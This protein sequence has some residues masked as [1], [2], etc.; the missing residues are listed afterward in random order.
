MEGFMD[1]EG[2]VKKVMEVSG[3]ESLNPPQRLALDAGLLEGKNLVVATPTASGKTAIAEI[4]CLKTIREG[5]KT[6]YI[7]PLK[8]LATEKYNEFK[9]KYEP[10]GVKVAVSIGDFDSSG[11]WL[12][13][14][15]LIVTTSERLDSLLRH[16]IGWV[17][18]VGLIVADE[19]HLLDSPERG[20]TL[21]IVLTRIAQ[22]ARPR[23]LALSATIN[24]YKELASWLGAEGI[25][26][27]Y[28][29][30]KLH[31]GL[32]F[33]DVVDFVPKKK[34]RLERGKDPTLAIVEENLKN[35]KQVLVFV[36]TRR[37]AEAGAEKLGENVK[38]LLSPAEKGNL[39]KVAEKVERSLEHTTRQCRRLAAC[40]RNGVAFHHAGETAQQRKLIEDAFRKGIIKV[41]AATPTLSWGINLPAY[42]V[43]VRD[44]K[45]FS[46]YRGMDYLP[47][48]EVH[49]MM[50]RAGRPKYDKEGRAVLIAKNKREAEYAWENYINGEPENIKSKLGV[51]PVLRMHILALIASGV[52]SKKK[53]LM[54]FF[55][56]TFYA[57]QF[58]DIGLLEGKVEKVLEM[59]EGFGF[60]EIEGKKPGIEKDSAFRR[61]SDV[62]SEE[63][64]LRPTKIGKRVSELYI[65]PLT[66]DHMIKNLKRF[67]DGLSPFGLLQTISDTIEMRP[68]PGLR[69]KD[70]EY[71]DKAVAQEGKNLVVPNEWDLEYD[72][73]LRS[74]KLA[75]TLQQW[76][77]EAGEDRILEDYNMTPGE[78]RARLNNA[79]WLLY[80]ISELALLLGQMGVLKGIRK[81]RVRMKYGVREE[82]LALVKLEG[83][84]RVRARTLFKSGLKSLAALRKVPLESL[85][86]IVGPK[87]ARD[88][89]E[90]LGEL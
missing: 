34:M 21:E 24:N 30:V 42:T 76:V 87:T 3:F 72:D 52:T 57:H 51:E 31:R 32:C 17:G 82:L 14:F 46:S 64:E 10:L 55:A 45:R 65:D 80:A 62:V 5:K 33:K 2:I 90:Q 15:D 54:D 89:K 50:G 84:G 61:A 73:F 39:A 7:V 4:S 83:I 13:R 81:M 35:K 86:R 49:Q 36:S 71:L 1:V 63:W 88:V 78:L 53:D 79:D 22:V 25:K 23:V 41:I 9:E 44:L 43:V 12:S 11:G 29:P 6:V 56:K 66:A 85:E 58:K 40:I 68:L 69:K 20:P 67:S 16:N 74:V 37:N 60:I 75:C 19:I 8:A 48:L 26:S 70:F 77:D 28:R 27:D 38:E 59:L 47:V 18:D